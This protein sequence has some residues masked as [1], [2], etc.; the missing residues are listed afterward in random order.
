ME[1]LKT[2]P[3]IEKISLGGSPPASGNTSTTTMKFKNGDKISETMVEIKYADTAYFD[4]YKM[5]LVAGKNLQQSDTTKEF[6]INETYAKLLGFTKPADAIGHF[7]ERDHNVPVSGV[8]SDFHTKSTHQAIKP[9]A[10]S[11][12]MNNSYTFHL[13]LKP[14]GQDGESWKRAL[15]KVEKFYKEIY[16]EDDFKYEF[17]D[18]SI[19]NFYKTEQD[20]SRLLKWSAGLCIFISCLGLLGL[21]MYITGTRTK[22]IGVRKVLGASVAQ[23]VSLLSKDFLSLI[24]VAF[25]IT[26][27]VAW[28]VMNNWLEDFVYRTSLSWWVFAGTGGGMLVISMLILSM[29]TIKSAIQNPVQS[30]R[31]E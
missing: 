22:E 13:A 2:I 29:R 30:L 20:I 15:S 14:R 27:P 10:Y 19:A 7:I 17:Y 23:I 25:L 21:V 11:S 9:L 16:P 3:E 31:T 12:A 24:L 28:W 26:L 1:K 6:I 4:L 8:I 18:E 5:K